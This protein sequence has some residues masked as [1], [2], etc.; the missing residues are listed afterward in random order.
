M[1]KRSASLDSVFSALADPTRRRILHGL[2]R[3]GAPVASVARP[4][5][6]SAPAV[7]RHLRVLE[8]SGLIRRTRRGRVHEIELNAAPL[9]RAVDWLEIYRQHWESSLDSLA[10]FLETAKPKLSQKPKS[11]NKTGKRK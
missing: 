1:V 7:S 5:R 3:G 2:M 8:R 4:F 6:M 9:R 11:K 10:R